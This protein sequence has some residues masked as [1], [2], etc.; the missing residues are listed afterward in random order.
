MVDQVP[1]V[2]PFD[3][4]QLCVA[5]LVGGKGAKLSQLMAAGHRVPA[6][7]C[8]TVHA[9][10]QFVQQ[11]SLVRRIQMELGRK[12][13]ANTRWE[14]LWDS[15][16]RIR[17]F[18]LS[19]DLSSDFLSDIADAYQDLPNSDRLVVRS[20]ATDEDSTQSFAGLHES[21]VDVRGIDALYEAI[22]IVWASLWSD[23]ALLYRAEMN[24]DPESS[25]MAV[26]VQQLVPG[27]PSGVAFARDPRDPSSDACIIEAV[28]G[29]NKQLVDGEIDPDRWILDRISGGVLEHRRGIR[30]NMAPDEALLNAN[31]LATL[32]REVL[33]VEDLFRWAPDVEWTGRGGQ[34]TLLQARP[35]TT[36]GAH[37]ADTERQWYLSLRPNQHRLKKLAEKVSDHLIPELM[38]LGDELAQQRIEVLDD[39]GLALCVK[40]RLEIVRHWRQVYI[41]DFIPLAHGVRQLGAFYNAAVKPDDPYE[42]MGLLEGEDMLA[43]RRNRML[44]ELAEHVSTDS[45][46]QDTLQIYLTDVAESRGGTWEEAKER[47]YRTDG[48]RRFAKIF[49]DLMARFTDLAFNGDRLST[50]PELFVHT[51]LELSRDK[52]IKPVDAR[53]QAEDRAIRH[54]LEDRLIRAVGQN[55]GDHAREMIEIGRLSWRLRDDDNIL[56]G[57]LESQLVRALQITADRLLE[58]GHLTEYERLSDRVSLILAE[59]LLSP[60]SEPLRLN[61]STKPD[62]EDLNI[63][64]GRPRQLVGQ[65]A[66]PGIASGTAC[67]VSSTADLLRIRRGQILV[68][69]AIQPNMTHIVPLVSGIVERRGGML[70]H[71]AI[72]AR[73]LGIPCVNG[74][75]D[76]VGLVRN[77][78]ILTVDGYLGIVT[79][80]EPEFNLEGIPRDTTGKTVV[81]G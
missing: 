13:R 17:A 50:R 20:S 49:T 14:E 31:D 66:G 53:K 57:R 54:S 37:S 56:V 4:P 70:I 36:T 21:V 44:Q 27:G 8:I 78:E 75:A 62:S 77:G 15:A 1:L 47:L 55:H 3:N 34:L 12:S 65:P 16:L 46:T 26:V 24:L 48:G 74:V 63:S 42:F 22:R 73:E 35:I 58:R 6:G 19:S 33:A 38:A 79:V 61:Q 5:S 80:G 59:A 25:A 18:F 68:C 43:S 11:N 81:D 10:R 45:I 7:F 72:I 60:P 32:L 41:D 23:A 29:M 39:R 67:V 40:E 76:A 2:V 28:P 30:D 69:D 9:Y 51:I 64:E 71:G 52:A